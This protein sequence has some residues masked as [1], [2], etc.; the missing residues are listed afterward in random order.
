M[1]VLW[2]ISIL[3]HDPEGAVGPHGVDP[4][5]PARWEDLHLCLQHQCGS[6]TLL[7]YLRGFYGSSALRVL[8]ELLLIHGQYLT[9]LTQRHWTGSDQNHGQGAVQGGRHLQ[10]QLVQEGRLALRSL[11]LTGRFESSF[12][13]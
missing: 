1:F 8:T 10:K 3:S 6:F 12:R 11:L 4:G 7:W 2:Q 9:R 5:H 13:K